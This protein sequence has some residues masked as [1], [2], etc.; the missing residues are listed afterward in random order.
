MNSNGWSV[1]R[2]AGEKV[3]IEA[4]Y[5]SWSCVHVYVEI[6]NSRT[7]NV[8]RLEVDEDDVFPYPRYQELPAKKVITATDIRASIVTQESEGQSC[9][10]AEPIDKTP[11]AKNEV[12]DKGS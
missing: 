12:V 10:R 7:G 4:T 1:L 11:T 6:K 5:K 2:G 8:V 9:E 3:L